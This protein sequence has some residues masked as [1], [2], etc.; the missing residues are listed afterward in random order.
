[1]APAAK[2]MEAALEK[3]ALLGPRIPVIANVTAREATTP[4]E[5]RKLLVAQVTG[6][7]RWTESIAYMAGQGA[8]QFVEIGAGKVLAGLV[9]RIAKDAA[10]LS[11]GEPG[12]VD[13]FVKA[14]G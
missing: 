11:V 9:K 1:M 5:I 4:A 2:T 13:T 10:I 3:A 12:D 8:D 7:V 6:R 14:A